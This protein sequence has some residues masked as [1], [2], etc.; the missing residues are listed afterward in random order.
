MKNDITDSGQSTKCRQKVLIAAKRDLDSAFKRR[1]L[2]QAFAGLTTVI[3]LLASLV[4]AEV[5]INLY[6]IQYLICNTTTYLIIHC[7]FHIN[8]Q[9]SIKEI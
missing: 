2:V 8:E 4:W 1:K 6:Y 7:H 3:F 5:F 9:I